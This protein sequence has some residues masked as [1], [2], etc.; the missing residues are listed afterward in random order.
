MPIFHYEAVDRTGKRINSEIEAGSIQEAQQK[1]RQMGYFPTGVQEKSATSTGTPGPGAATTGKKLKGFYLGG[2]SRKQLSHFTQ[3]LSVLQDAG[4]PL[5]R[6]L[7]ILE[8]Q[9]KTSLLKRIVGQVTE[10]VEG[11]STFSEA[12][13]KYPKA[14]DRLYV[15]MV[16]AG[17]AGGVLD[18][19][20]LR[21]S[22]FMEK[23][24]ALKRKIIGA[25]I[26]PVM[27]IS[28]ALVILVG[29]MAFVVPKF[30]AIFA[31]MGTSLP[32]MTQLLMSISETIKNWWFLLPVIPIVLY[33]GVI[34]FARS[35]NGRL[36]IDRLKLNVPLVGM[37]MRK[38]AIARFCRTFGTLLASGVNILESLTIVRNAI[39]NEVLAEAIQNVHDSIR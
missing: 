9:M 25:L 29:I 30:A 8:K 16:K 18:T 14:F 34:I 1:I 15:N 10:E 32:A 38:S 17:E 7:K 26:Y 4:L 11:G 21:L 37:I 39:G 31:E 28:V 3:Q 19:I 27:V 23:S 20:L 5:L 24:Q 2:V 35:R 33:I 6:S 36:T 22:I 12:L 13:S